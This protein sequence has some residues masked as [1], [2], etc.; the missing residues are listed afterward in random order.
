ML[1]L[2]P[3]CR[4][5]VLSWPW[6]WALGSLSG[7]TANLQQPSWRLPPTVPLTRQPLQADLACQ[8]KEL[9]PENQQIHRQMETSKMRPGGRPQQHRSS[10]GGCQ[11]QKAGLALQKWPRHRAKGPGRGAV[12]AEDRGIEGSRGLRVQRIKGQTQL[13][14]A[15]HFYGQ[16][17]QL[18]GR[19]NTI[20]YKGK[21][22]RVE[23]RINEMVHRFVY[24]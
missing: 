10:L 14:T 16:E 5:S 19:I 12:G 1:R 17:Q 7:A 4:P 24:S 20:I 18:F 21:L 15:L 6:P 8:C 13:R 11:C 3:L 23:L 22:S 9:H 2:W